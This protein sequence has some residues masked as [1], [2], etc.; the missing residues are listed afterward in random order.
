MIK[1][2]KNK[3]VQQNKDAKKNNCLNIIN[4]ILPDCKNLFFYTNDNFFNLLDN[5]LVLNKIIE[6]YPSF[7]LAN[8]KKTIEK[9]L[10][11]I[12]EDD[13]FMFNIL[14][15]YNINIFDFFKMLHFNYAVIF[16]GL[17]L[18]KIKEI[19]FRKDYAK[20]KKY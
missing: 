14:K 20:F 9:T 1:K 4:N 3:T 19:I 2:N 13:Q 5:R 18:K 7:S 8:D 11:Q 10:I 17:Y 15:K 16:K 12:L 6:N